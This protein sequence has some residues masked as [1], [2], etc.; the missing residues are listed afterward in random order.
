MRESAD[1]CVLVV[2]ARGGADATVPAALVPG[3]GAA[4]ALYG[5]AELT[6]GDDEIRITADGTAFAAWA[7][8]GVSA[9]PPR[10]H[11]TAPE[12]EAFAQLGGPAD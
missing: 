10:A 2:A 8:P 4:R 9:P 5:D 7:L 11:E 12:Y 3:A 6:V 1:E